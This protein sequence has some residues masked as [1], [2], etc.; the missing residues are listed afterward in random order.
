MRFAGHQKFHIREGWLLKGL[1]LLQNPEGT[2]LFRNR[3]E[4]AKRLSLGLNM[5]RSLRYWLPATRLVKESSKGD[6]ELTALGQ[7]ILDYDPYLES[8]STLWLIHANLA[9][10]RDDA[11]TWY[12]F[13]NHYR[14][15]QFS[16]RD[17]IAG[18]TE[19]VILQGGVV[20]G[21]SLAAD[22]TCLLNTY[23][24]ADAEADDEE[25]LEC[26]LAALGLLR[27][28]GKDAYRLGRPRLTR[29]N[30][31][32]V[33]RTMVEWQNEHLPGSNQ[34]Q[35]SQVLREPCNAGAVFA[36]DSVGLA[37]VLGR[38]SDR[39]P[40]YAAKFV[41]TAGL[42][43]IVLPPASVEELTQEIFRQVRWEGIA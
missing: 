15:P 37:E 30:P 4:A 20:S 9:T 19:W 23:V 42:E 22:A 8:E 25:S 13:F 18:L 32:L 17:L 27:Q 28:V 40:Q 41:R 2:A 3:E 39:F 29:L 1:R 12:W 34:V 24:S 7:L 14:Q 38:L 10:N 16:R 31:V 21:D 5:V 35:F 43:S 36:L 11:T 6:M 26:P 33:L